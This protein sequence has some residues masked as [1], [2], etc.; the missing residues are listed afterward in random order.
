MDLG[1]RGL[2]TFVAI[3]AAVLIAS[4]CGSDPTSTPTQ[5]IAAAS[6]TQSP[7][8]A[9]LAGVPEAP[10]PTSTSTPT[11]TP[12]PTPTPATTWTKPRQVG[13]L[14]NCSA[15]TA[16]IDVASRYHVAAECAGSIH[17]YV[18][19]DGRSWT[20]SVFSH[21]ANRQ[22]LGPQVAF[23]GNV[24]YVGYTRIALVDGGCGDSGIRDVGVYFRSRNQ[25]DGGWSVPV[26]IGAPD[27]RLDSFRVDGETIHATVYNAGDGHAYY[28]TLN[29][30]TFHRYRLPKT[31]SGGTLLRIGNDGRAR[32]AFQS[33]GRIYYGVFTGGVF[34]PI[35]GTN[36]R[37]MGANLVLDSSD[38]AHVVWTR[39]PYLIP[40]GGCAYGDLPQHKDMGTYYATNASGTWQSQRITRDMGETS[41]QV[42]QKTGRVHILVNDRKLR[43]YTSAGDGKWSA[44]TV[45]SG[46]ASSPL[47]RL[48]P[49]T[50]TLLIVYLGGADGT[51]MYAMTKP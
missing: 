29:G 8:P 9:T 44:S 45:P 26:R 18:S 1:H 41:L 6:P 42:D 49:A 33:G 39:L 13:T 14:A 37:D 2:R 28:E 32:I 4:G 38:K 20:A 12:K 50:G 7:A 19:S 17:S 16:G 51:T 34:F 5:A 47:L 3:A 35:A 27:D 22:D 25:P 21:P 11:P 15:V 24:V 46:S 40:E 31:S 10:A 30:S 48:D 43:Y 36:G 23:M